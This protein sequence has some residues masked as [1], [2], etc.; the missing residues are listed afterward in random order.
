M[1]TLDIYRAGNLFITIKPDDSSTQ[2]KKVMG[3]NILQL[4][5]KDNRF[6]PFMLNDYCVVYGEIY[7]LNTLPTS[8]KDS[9][10]LFEYTLTLQADG[11]NLAKAQFLFLGADNTLRES[12]FSLMGT[13]D[14]FIDLVIQNANRASAGWVKG[15]VID[16]GYHN[17]TFSGSNCYDALG[18]LATEF[19][20][21]FWID[22]RT[23]HLTGRSRDTGWTFRQGRNKGLY[24]ITRLQQN[25]T[26][27]V[28]RLYAFGSDK[29][30]PAG[31][32]NYTPRLLMTDG[33]YSL[34]KN[35]DKYGVVEATQL[36]DDIFPT[37][38]GKVTSVDAANFYHFIDASMDFDLNTYLLPGLTAKV[39]F[40]TGQLSG[41]TFEL[42]SYDNA[43][44]QFTLLQNKDETAIVVP[45]ADLKPAIGD[46]YVLVDISLP[47]S[48]IDT[49]EAKLKDTAQTFLDANCEP[50]VIYQITFDQVYLKKRN[51]MPAI[52][53]AVWLVD[54][55]YDVDR[56]I[57]IT[58]TTRGIINEWD[59]Q[60]EL[61]DNITPGTI[62]LLTQGVADNALGLSA[63]NSTLQNTAI[64]NRRIIGDLSVSQG[65]IV[66]LD[67]PTTADLT[68]FSEIV[69]QNSTG[70]VYRKI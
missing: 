2:T 55:D 21:E 23:I 26:S 49:A 39:T 66:L 52:G 62:T 1:D 34:D 47:Q 13:A 45:S 41:Y 68:G 53:D 70:R 30:L 25:N 63:V 54:N 57:R 60:V 4:T 9:G 8:K 50:L 51:I 44:K 42:S 35:V 64:L 5:F 33:I 6:I 59:L 40:N 46:S 32:R 16:D 19:K 31:Y 48:Y 69:V 58:S 56:R 29:N 17:M 11:F 7:S 38:T 61:A 67:L 22:G 27:V 37:R 65:T 14:D 15:T 18:N 43:T 24:D 20:T 36:F 3:D 12:D 10:Y 28:T